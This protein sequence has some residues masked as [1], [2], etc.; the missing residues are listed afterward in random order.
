MNRQHHQ[1]INNYNE[2]LRLDPF[3]VDAHNRRGSEYFKLGNIKKSIAD[4]D[5][6]I[7]LDPKHIKFYIFNKE[8]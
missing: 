6:A 5:N 4:F 3:F 8:I 1:A 2:V 7:N